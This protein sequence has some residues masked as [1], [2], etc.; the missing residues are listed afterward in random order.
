MSKS[1]PVSQTTN[2]STSIPEWLTQYTQQAAAQ[3]AALPQYTPYTGANVQAGLTPNQQQAITEASNNAGVGQ[4]MIAAGYNPAQALTSFSAAPVNA[5][6]LNPEITSLL[7]PATAATVQATNA[8]IQ[9][10]ADQQQAQLDASL[11]GSGAWGGTRQAVADATLQGDAARTQALTDAQVN[12]QNYDTALSTALAA[13]QGNQNAA[14]QSAG[15][16]ATGVNLLNALGGNFTGLTSA[17]LQGLLGTGGTAQQTTTGQNQ[18]NY[19]QYLEGYQ[20][21]DTQASTFASILGSMPYSTTGTSQTTGNVYTNGLTGLLGLGLSIGAMPVTGGG[22]LLGNFLTSD[23]RRK[24]DIRRVGT[25]FDGTP[26]YSY[27]YI[28]G[29]GETHIGVM[30]QDIEKT[31]P[32]AVV[33]HEGFKYVDYA[34]AT[35]HAAAIGA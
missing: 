4:Q 15:V 11:A 27:R 33:E 21:P 25:L 30:A 6:S 19:N 20:I 13:Q 17:D 28:G 1:Q 18:F 2:Q 35:D 23:R 16:N 14:V 31:T 10:T 7:N 8:D 9:H 34:A 22:S 5:L 12:T 32:H 29:T 3:G 24:K 26:I